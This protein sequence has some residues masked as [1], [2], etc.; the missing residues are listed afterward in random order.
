MIV[1]HVKFDRS[2]IAVMLDTAGNNNMAFPIEHLECRS[3]FLPSRMG[4]MARRTG[5]NLQS[6]P[7]HPG[8]LIILD[9]IKKRG[10]IID[11]LRMKE[12]AE[13]LDAVQKTAG[14]KVWL[15][16]DLNRATM[17][18][19]QV[20]SWWYWMQ[21]WVKR[22]HAIL[23]SGSFGKKPKGRILLDAYAPKG[24]AYDKKTKQGVPRWKDEFDHL[25]SDSEYVET[26]EAIT[27]Q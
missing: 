24:Q 18:D 12:Y 4:P 20:A 8:T 25:N 3:R 9:P 5:A 6:I 19:W 7:E 15:G 1:K 13:L 17:S 16:K 23:V 10:R 27:S 26:G 2:E 21:E 22:G 14:V 11:P